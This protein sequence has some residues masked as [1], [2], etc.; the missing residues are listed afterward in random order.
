[1]A[2]EAVFQVSVA[3]EPGAGDVL[4]LWRAGPPGAAPQAGTLW[5]AALPADL[6]AGDA[7]LAAQARRL[8][9]LA[10]AF[11]A[12]QARLRDDLAALPGPAAGETSFGL[13]Q[14]APDDPA[15]ILA[16]ALRYR[17]PDRAV[18]FGLFDAFQ[19]APREVEDSLDLFGRFTQQARQAVDGFA[20]V[21]TV[22]GGRRAAR[23]R[24]AWTGDLETWWAAGG[25]PDERRQ[26]EQVLAQALAARQNWLRFL[27][28]VTG[29]I[30]QVAGAL[31]AGPFAPL[32]V[33][34]AWNYFRRV[35]E[36]YQ[37]AA[38]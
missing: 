20:T 36:A 5:A 38:A 18:A 26:H 30:T 4:G 2:D 10:R 34:A 9:A 1:M 29:G 32:A 15:N 24:A 37:K 28:L 17:Y 7:L 19:P 8:A 23:T 12:A 33:W 25:L 16:A 13:G 27:L 14:P 6:E 3:G 22:V 31:A 21:E 11:P 35:I